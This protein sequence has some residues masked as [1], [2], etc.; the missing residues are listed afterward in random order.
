MYKMIRRQ[1]VFVSFLYYTGYSRIKNLF[2]RVQRKPIT[3]I[4]AFH[5]IQP[6]AFPNFRAN[7]SF[8]KSHT[9]VVSLEDYFSG[10]LSSNKINVI[11]TFDDGYK[12]WITCATPTLKA[13]G[14]P[15]TF[16]VT[17]GFVGLSREKEAEF[18]RNNLFI[19]LPS[20]RNSGGLSYEDVRSIAEAGFTIGGHTSNHSNLGQL[21]DRNNIRYEIAE[22][23]MQLERMTRTKINYFA[24]PSGVFLNPAIDLVEVLKE[25]GY[26][27][28]V[29]TVPGFN[30]IESNPFLLR[31]DLT[32]ATMPGPVFRARA[33][34]NYDLVQFIK[35]RVLKYTRLP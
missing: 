27:G 34:G 25:S 10:R 4:V 15:A 11:I 19:W 31:R 3:R 23:K 30:T 14:L 12:S 7:I 5:D 17:T 24:Y 21:Q 13:L 28:A 2:F 6:E 1:D 32:S 26:K 35:E 33:Y 29:T 16:F 18:M 22:D 20:R 9:N 8:L